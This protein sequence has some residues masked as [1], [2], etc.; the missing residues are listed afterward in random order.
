MRIALFYFVF[1][2][3]SGVLVPYLPAYFRSL[4]FSGTEISIVLSLS[5][6]MMIFIPLLWGLLADRT[7]RPT[8]LLKLACAG[9]ALSFA[10]LPFTRQFSPVVAVLALYAFFA[11]AISSLADSI[12]VAEAKKTGTDYARLRLW[13]SLGYIVACFS[14]GKFLSSGVHDLE[15]AGICAVMLAAGALAAQVVPSVRARMPLAPSLADAGRLLADPALLFF[16]LAAMIHQAALQPYY[17]F[18][19]VYARDLHINTYYVGLGI[20]LGVAAEVLM[21]WFFRALCS[22][23]SLQALLLASF[24]S[25]SLRWYLLTQVESGPLLAAIQIFHGLTFGAFFIGSIV[26][27]ERA[28]PERLRATGR[29][30]FASLV[31]GLGGIIGNA[32][33]GRAYDRG[34]G[35]AAFLS[36]AML[37]LLAPLALLAS[38]RFSRHLLRPER[39][40]VEPITK[41]FT[42][43]DAEV[44]RGLHRENRN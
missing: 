24:F 21:M 26:Y 25:S 34:G 10:I 31:S 20:S 39:G 19:A 37:E 15:I 27:L 33:A 6:F 12:A 9:S 36:S 43:E 42:A 5:S 30:L 2:G 40:V 44:R 3:T 11:T 16:F 32:I 17:L 28:V 7:G 14:F 38:A 8:L 35:K 41:V 4:G 22:R 29:A 23:I 1:Y 18:L 13:G